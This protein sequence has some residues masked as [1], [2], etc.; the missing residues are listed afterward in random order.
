M[1]DSYSTLRDVRA[2]LAKVVASDKFSRSK[3]ASAMLTYIVEETLAGRAQQLKAY[4]LAIDVFERPASFNPETDTVVRVQASR[5]RGML[6]T[7]YLSDGAD[8]P[9]HI[10]VPRGGYAAV[11]TPQGGTLDTGVSGA[12]FVRRG[13]FLPV[14]VGL[15][16]AVVAGFFLFERVGGG[17]TNGV[18]QTGNGVMAQV[19]FEVTST[20]AAG[21]KFEELV[22]IRAEG[23]IA[24]FGQMYVPKSGPDRLFTGSKQPA[25]LTRIVISTTQSAA[26]AHLQVV[27]FKSGAN[28][29]SS[30]VPLTLSG[31]EIGL[32]PL[33]LEIAKTYS[34]VGPVF[35]HLQERADLSDE[36]MC[37]LRTMEILRTDAHEEAEIQDLLA[38]L[39]QAIEQYPTLGIAGVQLAVL[40]INEGDR[41]HD[42]QGGSAYTEAR[43][44]L[45]KILAISPNLPG[46]LMVMA[47]ATFVEGDIETAFE[48]DRRV[49]A[50]NPNSPLIQAQQGMHLIRAGRFAAGKEAMQKSVDLSKQPRLLHQAYLFLAML[51]TEGGVGE[52]ELANILAT[53][54]TAFNGIAGFLANIQLGHDDRAL[55]I[56]SELDGGALADEAF[57]MAALFDQRFKPDAAQAIVDRVTS[58][59]IWRS[60]NN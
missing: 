46:A 8:D 47:M 34:Q 48:F 3:R 28:I 59:E 45:D 49:V 41:G 23:T 32:E 22:K 13:Y 60:A 51:E 21:E 56:I 24:R 6:E 43:R 57:L 16:L 9:L 33:E 17:S 15:I 7:Y 2:A 1:A 52:D 12:P 18:R 5:L 58:T 11:F 38:C 4:S 37:V 14:V 54:Q 36:L 30:S 55:K 50:I 53:Q 40:L 26:E 42:Y 20:G 27:D 39:H 35:H 29:A 25:Y 19:A 44:V 10:S 31:D